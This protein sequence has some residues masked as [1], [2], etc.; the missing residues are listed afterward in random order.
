ML[1]TITEKTA[2]NS[3]FCESSLGFYTCSSDGE[4]IC[5]ERRQGEN[6]A[7]CVEQ[8]KGDDCEKCAENYYPENTCEVYCS[9][10][11]NRYTC[12]DQGQK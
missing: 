4:K 11:L 1:Q 2:V 5:E 12:I 7:D 3:D 6:C 10:K 9:P 8:F